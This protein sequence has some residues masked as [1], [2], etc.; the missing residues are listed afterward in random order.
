METTLSATQGSSWNKKQKTTTFVLRIIAYLGA[1][2]WNDNVC[3]SSDARGIVFSTLKTS[4]DDPSVLLVDGNDFLYLWYFHQNFSCQLC[5]VN[6]Y[7]DDVSQYFSPLLVSLSQIRCFA[8]Y[9]NLC[10]YF[11]LYMLNCGRIL[12]LCLCYLLYKR[13]EINSVPFRSILFYYFWSES[14]EP[15]WIYFI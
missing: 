14:L 2:L 1:K 3:N 11:F 5:F 9:V 12:A 8:F 7:C 4:I 6:G 13:P 10:P 15:F